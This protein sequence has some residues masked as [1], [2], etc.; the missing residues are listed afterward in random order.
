MHLEMW[1][2]KVRTF[3]E[4]NSMTWKYKKLLISLAHSSNLGLEI[5][6][7]VFGG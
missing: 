7:D 4:D 6:E 3:S 1:T 2:L 5:R